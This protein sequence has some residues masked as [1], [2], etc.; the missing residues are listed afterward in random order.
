MSRSRAAGDAGF[1][2]AEVLVSMAV[3]SI[4]MA[5]ASSGF[6]TMFHTSDT[7]ETTAAAQAELQATFNKLDREIR[8]ASRISDGYADSTTFYIDFVFLDDAGANQCVQ[9]SLPKAGGTMKRRQWPLQ[10]TPS[11]SG[12]A[13]ANN[14][15]SARL[16]TSTPKQVI[17]PFLL[18]ASGDGGSV[19]DR[20]N[21]RVNSVVGQDVSKQGVREYDL[22]FTAM[23]TLA[24]ATYPLAC[25]H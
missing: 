22:Q 1:S 14:L 18:A 19:M 2:L 11:G 9:L 8:Y 12:T 6:Y 3:M 25:T 10:G 4:V 24:R 15:V 17:N 7:A 16:D 13:V 21:L 20:L 23:N 5:I